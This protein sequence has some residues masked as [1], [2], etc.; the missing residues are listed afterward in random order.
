VRL[1]DGAVLAEDLAS[2]WFV[3]PAVAGDDVWWIGANASHV[4]RSDEPAWAVG[5]RLRE[6][7]PGKLAVEPRVRT[8]VPTREPMY[9]SPLV[10][11][12]ALI[13]VDVVGG[14]WRV[15]RASGAVSSLGTV[16]LGPAYTSP[17]LVGGELWLG[18]ESGRLARV[19]PRAGATPELSAPLGLF[20]STPVVAGGRAFLRTAAGVT[21]LGGSP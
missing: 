6:T 21:C 9:T 17:Q 13:A 20:R 16:T 18:G 3:G 11:T 1:D 5:V 19:A 8:A 14:V 2:P 7:A 12:D 10:L 15:D 4:M